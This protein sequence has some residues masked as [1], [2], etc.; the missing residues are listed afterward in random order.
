MPKNKFQDVVFTIIMATFMVYGMVFYNVALN[1]GGVTNAT[2]LMALHELPIMVP[3]AFVLEFFIVGKLAPAIAFTF[4]KPDDR[5]FF[6]TVAISTC[7]CCIMCPVMSLVATILFKENPSFGT[8]VQ[9]WAMNFPMA[10]FYQLC[11]CG[12]L[13]RFIFKLI[14]K[15]K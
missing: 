4:M 9:T 7:I 12:P 11:Y 6:I 5:P 14:F 2:F 8:W 3:V 10:L 15:E 13:V 1:T